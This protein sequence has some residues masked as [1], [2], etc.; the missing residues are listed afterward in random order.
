MQRLGIEETST[1][2]HCELM[3]SSDFNAADESFRSE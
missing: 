1:W 3:L 2:F